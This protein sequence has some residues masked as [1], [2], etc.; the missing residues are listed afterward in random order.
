MTKAIVHA[1]V[2]CGRVAPNHVDGFSRVPN[3][4]IKWACDRDPLK[5]AEFCQLHNIPSQT[6]DF[7][8]VL[9]DPEVSS[10]SIAVDHAQHADLAIAALTMGKHVLVEKPLAIDVH[11]AARV[12]EAPI[13]QAARRRF[14]ASV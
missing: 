3:C 2:G 4:S 7:Y 8:E 9:R 11:N 12:V 10:V 14:S 13:R 6:T 5:L 1:L